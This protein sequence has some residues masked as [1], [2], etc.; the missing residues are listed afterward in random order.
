[1]LRVAQ[2]RSNEE[3]RELQ[4]HWNSLLSRSICDTVFLTWEWCTTWWKNYGGNREMFI[5]AAWNGREVVGIAPF[6]IEEVC[7]YGKNWKRL[8]LVG[9][10]SH[11]SDYLDCFT[12]SKY[13]ADAVAA[14]IDFLWTKRELWDWIELCGPRMNSSCAAVFMRCAH[15]RGWKINVEAIPCASLRLPSTWADYL[16]QLEP[17][18]R[19]KVRS[20]LSVLSD[21]IKA[22]PLQCG[23]SQEMEDW[24]PILFDL[25]TR[26]WASE[27]KPGVFRD[28]VKRAFYHD[29]SRSALD[30]GWLAFHRLNWGERPLA[31]QY[32]LVYR[33]CFHLLQEGYDPEFS[34][35]RPGFA[36]RAWL[37][38]H[39]IESGLQEYDFLTG[40]PRHKLDWGAKEGASSC[41]VISA[42]RAGRATAFALPRLRSQIREHIARVVPDAVLLLRRKVIARDTEERLQALDLVRPTQGVRKDPRLLRSLASLA[43][44]FAPVSATGRAIATSYTWRRSFQ[45]WCIAIRRR[46]RSVLHIFQYHRVNDDAD[47]FFGGLAIDLFRAQMEYI[48]RNFPIV[49]LDQ[50]AANDLSSGHRYY[51]ALTFDDGYRDNFSCA[52][53][54]LKRLGIPATIFLATEYVDSDQLPWY[55]Q[56]RLAFKLT[57]RTKFVIEDRG[58]PGGSLTIRSSR[59]RSMEQTLGWLRQMPDAERRLAL[60][61]VY[62][63]LAVPSALNLPN[64][65][66]HWEDVRQMSKHRI[67]FG[68]HT[69]THPVLS[70]ISKSQ[71]KPE[72]AGSKR[73]IENRLQRPVLHF[74]YPFGQARD[75]N[76]QAKLAVRDAGFKT[77]VTTIW[78]LNEPDDD[79]LELKR[80][81][82]WESNLVDF[83][84][85]LDWFRFREP[86]SAEIRKMEQATAPRIAQEAGI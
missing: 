66:L 54:I 27:S 69:V 46:E 14:F 68:A 12:E 38:R 29:L 50:V 25:H 10:G 58:G 16:R 31:L 45:G 80:F 51:A 42:S 76:A 56:V 75:F 86:G 65:M 78:G 84:M 33:N 15:E 74:A 24:L 11:D 85:K 13:E 35:V 18:F 28:P 41:L 8:R 48:S 49:A 83:K 39:W 1:M 43:Y 77:A 6:Y 34:S 7:Q 36:M 59:L 55:D 82:P 70:R 81:T 23:S 62:D 53:P 21:T 5:L 57:T 47:P 30:R 79:L 2:Y 3:L 44:S 19:T 4:P 72:I 73:A 20:S 32:G 63:A 64:Q 52:F 61:K 40:T 9:D 26:R 67:S 37:M 17:R 71:L 22:A 60:S